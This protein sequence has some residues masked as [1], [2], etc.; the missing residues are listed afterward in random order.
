[1]TNAESTTH[2]LDYFQG[3]KA[4]R[5]T[6]SSQSLLYF[7]RKTSDGT[8]ETKLDI[9]DSGRLSSADYYLASGNYFCAH[10]EI[11]KIGYDENAAQDTA[12]RLAAKMSDPYEYQMLEPAIIGTNDCIVVARIMNPPLV[13]AVKAVIYKGVTRRQEIM[14]AGGDLRKLI[15]SET[16]YY[17]RKSD[18]V[19]MGYLGRNN[20]KQ[21][22]DDFLYDNV[23]INVPIPN[24]EFTLPAGPVK[25]A[26]TFKDFQRIVSEQIAQD[27][28]HKHEIKW[29]R[30]VMIG[31]FAVSFVALL[32]LL[33]S[34]FQHRTS[35]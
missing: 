15:R 10:G 23:Q 16:D 24:Q 2:N 22:L 26:A 35:N 5:T 14:F 9:F 4:H 11:A 31:L 7:Q 34:R 27:R 29:F 8:V 13:D 25:L 30:P 21:L 20:S 33:Y 3:S 17:I 19:V 18:D 12:Q 28:R 6:D 1:M 32:A